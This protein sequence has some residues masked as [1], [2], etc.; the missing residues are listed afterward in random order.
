MGQKSKKKIDGFE[1]WHMEHVKKLNELSH[2]NPG[3]LIKWL[4][5]SEQISEN[6]E[7]NLVNLI[8]VQKQEIF[9]KLS[10]NKESLNDY[11]FIIKKFKTGD[12]GNDDEF[13]KVYRR[14]YVLNGAGLTDKFMKRYFELLSR[15]E[16]DLK[17]LLWELSKIPRRKGDYS[18]QLSFASKLI[19]TIDNNQPIYD[20]RVAELLDIELDYNIKDMSKRI[21][22]RIEKYNLLKKKFNKILN[23]QEIKK[24]IKDFKIKLKTNIGDVKMLDFI[25]W[26]LGDMIIKNEKLKSKNE[27]KN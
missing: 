5:D 8:K 3:P 10:K 26:K 22:D 21:D 20:S 25:L 18:I 17:K 16:A 14:F 11:E 13:K 4:I 12:V 9:N 1:K 6:E 23:K 15:K 27:R 19:H 24:I 2:E 7:E